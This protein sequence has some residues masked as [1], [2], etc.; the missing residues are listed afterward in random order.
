MA[1][2]LKQHVAPQFHNAFFHADRDQKVFVR[3]KVVPGV[4]LKSPTGQGYEEDAFTVMNDGERDA[5]CDDANK[6][7]EDW[8]LLAWPLCLLPRPR[9]MT[10]GRLSSATFE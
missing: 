3:K 6:A 8:W 5:S 10:N 1:V 4:S 2:N 9:L 7:I